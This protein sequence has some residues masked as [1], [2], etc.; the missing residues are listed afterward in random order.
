MKKVFLI[1]LLIFFLA[2]CGSPSVEIISSTASP[3]GAAAVK[4]IRL[5]YHATVPYVWEVWLYAG[6][7]KL[8]VV[9]RIV[10][11]DSVDVEWT[12]ERNVLINYSGGRKKSFLG[13]YC[14]DFFRRDCIKINAIK[15]VR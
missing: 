6:N 3:D 1:S 5:N 13:E 8:A 11:P 10:D 7:E 14:L 12:N 2:G 9:A 15:S 4:I